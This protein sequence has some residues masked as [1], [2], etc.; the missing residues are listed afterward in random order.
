M[1]DTLRDTGINWNLAPVWTRS[2]RHP[3]VVALGRTF[4]SIRSV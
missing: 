2:I 4:S 3:A 1:G